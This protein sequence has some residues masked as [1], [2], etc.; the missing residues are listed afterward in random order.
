M[1]VTRR[2]ALLI[3]CASAA[4]AAGVVAPQKARAQAFNANPTT[5]NGS[6]GYDRATPGVETVSIGGNNAVIDWA[7]NVDP[8]G[9]GNIDFLPF[10]NT[11]TFEGPI[12]NNDFTV[13]NRVTTSTP[14]EMNGRVVSNAQG[15]AAGSG[16]QDLVLQPGRDPGRLD[17]RVRRRQPAADGQQSGLQPRHR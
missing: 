1:T 17:R 16:R 15:A 14:I 8:N 3:S 7:P 13:L 11:A 10:G 6:V 2:K 5:I 4:I 12:G 9:N